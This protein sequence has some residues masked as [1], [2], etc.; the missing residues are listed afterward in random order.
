M[1]YD[2][3]AGKLSGGYRLVIGDAAGQSQFVLVTD[4]FDLV[5]HLRIDV[6]FVDADQNGD[7]QAA[8]QL[9]NALKIVYA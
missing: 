9:G 4:V 6:C 7:V 3:D 5:G 2:A 1:F 8:R